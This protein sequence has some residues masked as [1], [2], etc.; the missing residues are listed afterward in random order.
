MDQRADAIAILKRARQ[1]L[2]ERLSQRVIDCQEEILE[3]AE[4]GMFHSELESMYENLGCRLSNVNALLAALQSGE[5][6]AP[7][8][9]S[10]ADLLSL[11][12]FPSE[13]ED[14]LPELCE[15]ASVF[16]VGQPMEPLPAAGPANMD[17]FLAEVQGDQIDQAAKTLAELFGLGSAR[18][19]HCALVFQQRWQESS[20]V[21]AKVARLREE[22]RAD[23]SPAA[24]GLLCECFGL[25]ETESAGVAKCLQARL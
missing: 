4:R 25:H 23:L 3:D 7:L 22:L 24:L 13:S 17:R 1:T 2:I 20:E 10:D 9:D 5:E 19:E 18:A 6:T 8:T 14:L 21:L 16:V 15:P 11:A 12:E